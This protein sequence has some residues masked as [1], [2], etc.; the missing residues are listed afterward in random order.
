MT[1]GH[2]A[3]RLVLV[4]AAT[5]M[6]GAAAASDPVALQWLDQDCSVGERGDLT[7]ELQAGGRRTENALIDAFERG[8]T[9]EA[10][11]ELAVE[12]G[13]QYDEVASALAAGRTYGLSDAEIASIR[14][15]SRQEHVRIVLGE[16]NRGYRAAALSGLGVLARRR[17]LR[18]LRR[19]AAEP[20]SPDRGAALVALRDAG[21]PTPP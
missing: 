20:N 3:G 10:L 13:R 9:V 1:F 2:A 4:L 12:A 14:A 15:I 11:D 18:L 19:V 17:G 8:P 6:P 16:F 21:Q 7:T 5:A